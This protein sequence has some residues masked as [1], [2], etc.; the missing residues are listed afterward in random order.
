MIKTGNEI[1][2]DPQIVTEKFNNYFIEVTE[3]LLSQ[4]NHHCPQHPKFQTKYCPETMFVAPITEAE[5]IQVIKSLKNNSSVGID[6]I[7][8]FLVKQYLCYFIKPL[9]HIYYV[10][11]QTGILPDM[12]KRAKVKSLFKQKDRQDVQN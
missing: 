5:V 7:P 11:F 3:N 12:M 8:T 1:I 2:M 10:S 9:V 4:I 6:E